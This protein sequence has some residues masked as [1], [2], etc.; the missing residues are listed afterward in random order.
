[1]RISEEIETDV[2]DYK[3]VEA[4]LNKLGLSAYCSRK[5]IRTSFK[6]GNVK[7]EIDEYTSIPPYLEIEGKNKKDILHAVNLLRYTMDDTTVMT[8]TEVL[9]HYGIDPFI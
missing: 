9:R 7:F 3:V 2:A 4:I 8:A 5:K 1:M 6:K